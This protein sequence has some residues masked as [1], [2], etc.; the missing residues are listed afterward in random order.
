MAKKIKGVSPLHNLGIVFEQAQDCRLE[1]QFFKK[2][3]SELS[4]LSGYL[5]VTHSQALWVAVIFVMDFQ[6]QSAGV[7]DLSGYLG[8]SPIRLFE[9]E[10]DFD[11]LCSKGI[12]LRQRNRSRRKLAGGGKEYCISEPIAEAILKGLPIPDP[13]PPGF[14]DILELLAQIQQMG[15]FRERDVLSTSEILEETKQILKDYKHFALIEKVNSFKLDTADAWLFLFL[16][17]GVISG[18]ESVHLQMV[19]QL[20][21]DNEL[22]RVKYIQQFFS[23]ENTLLQ[24]HLVQIE[25]ASFFND[26]EVNLTEHAV[27]LLGACN[28]Y[29]YFSESKSQPLINPDQIPSRELVFEDD[30]KRQ[31]DMV[32]RLLD[33]EALKKT[34]YRLETKGLSKGILILFHGPPGTGKTESALQMAKASKREILKVDISQSKSMWFGESQKLVKRIFA[35]YKVISKKCQ[36]TPILLFNEADALISKRGVVRSTVDQTENAIQNIL[37]EEME[38]FEG[39]LMAT[40]NLLVNLDPAFERRFLFKV[41]FKQPDLSLKPKLWLLKFPQLNEEDCYFLSQNFDFSGGQIDNIAR[42]AEIYEILNGIPV[43]LQ[44]LL[45]FC[46]AEKWNQTTDKI[47]FI[48]A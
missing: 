3:S 36:R 11:V 38:N 15:D 20:I 44:D 28:L 43:T 19:S 26:V 45:G 7:R 41:E 37:L 46:R 31:L 40:T 23:G 14:Q 24:Q 1:P 42:K 21:Y 29:A 48:R 35:D 32:C 34:Q 17:W 10:G 27:G 2:V 9:Y 12:L 39:I 4:A 6:G 47:G 8:C 5:G 18:Q 33:D 16:S 30:V 22:R 13:E 25:A